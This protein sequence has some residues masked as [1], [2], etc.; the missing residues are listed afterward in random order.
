MKLDANWHDLTADEAC[1][2]V[3]AGPRGLTEAEATRR[4]E[5]FGPNAIVEQTVRPVWRMVLDQFTDLMILV[6][7]TAA[8]ISGLIGDAQDSVIILAIVVLNAVVGVVQ[9]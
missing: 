1:C 5:R 9:E 7:I 8:I 3:E 6:L 2:S 4:L